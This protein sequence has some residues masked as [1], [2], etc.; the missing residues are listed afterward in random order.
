MWNKKNITPHCLRHSYATHLIES[1][2][3][4]QDVK[5]LLGHTSI[6]TTC[7]YT[8]LTSRTEN[9]TRQSINDLMK[10]FS[11]RWGNIS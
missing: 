6:I 2:V 3:R 8:H 4:L 9:N 1:G 5:D 7:K 10:D 11:I